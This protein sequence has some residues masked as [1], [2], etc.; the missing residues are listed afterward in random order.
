[1]V[2]RKIKSEW[3]ITQ[4]GD[5]QIPDIPDID[6]PAW[7]NRFAPDWQPERVYEK[8]DKDNICIMTRI[9]PSIG[10]T[11]V[12][13]K[14]MTEEQVQALP[15][16]F[17]S[18]SRHNGQSH[19]VVDSLKD[20]QKNINYWESML[21]HKIQTE[22]GGGSQ[23]VDP[24][25]FKDYNEYLRYCKEGNNPRARFETKEGLLIDGK[26]VPSKPVQ[27]SAFPR[28]VYENLNHMI[29]VI[30]PNIS[31]VTPAKLGQPG[32]E[33]QMSG[34]LYDMMRVQSDIQAYT[35]HKG[36][37]LFY[38]GV[39]ESYLLQAAQTYSNEM[40][41]RTFSVNKGRESITLNEPITLPDGR[42]GIK[43][44]VSRL[45][46]IRVKVIISEKQASPSEKRARINDLSNMLKEIP[47]DK[48][49]TRSIV[50]NKVINNLDYLEE[51]D[52]EMLEQADTMELELAQYTVLSQ[53]EAAKLN[54][55]NA[56]MQGKQL[57]QIP[58]EG[59]PPNEGS[60]TETP[61]EN[62]EQPQVEGA[63]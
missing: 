11:T 46:Q 56:Q 7:L 13:D 40:I 59:Q 62:P 39:Y 14:G 10:H 48:I 33:E 25:G 31:K 37:N 23:F 19:S 9:C 38:N 30:W 20:V 15:F 3:V 42:T 41:P 43:N 18:A 60:P 35:I 50:W 49:L 29:H 4:Q 54:I 16:H 53:I 21:T 12:L 57:T 5:I 27:N 1:M 6:K 28:E 17:W 32:Q 47:P 8:E 26:S 58:D 24:A 61:Q 36:L 63:I 2:E 34:K 52:R 22:G 55:L 51:D 45:K 44:D